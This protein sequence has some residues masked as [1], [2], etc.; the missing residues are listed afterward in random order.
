M[1]WGSLTGWVEG[2]GAPDSKEPDEGYATCSLWL[3][4]VS[5]G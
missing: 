2:Q 4:S 1:S 5:E 3:D